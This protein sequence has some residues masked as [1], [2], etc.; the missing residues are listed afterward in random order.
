MLYNIYKN[1]NL[2]LTI[3]DG[4]PNVQQNAAS[5]SMFSY[6]AHKMAERVCFCLTSMT[7]ATV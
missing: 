3:V 4:R 2:K 5:F 7:I 6:E 1:N